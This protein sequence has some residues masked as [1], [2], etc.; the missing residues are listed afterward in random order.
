MFVA[1]RGTF[2]D[3]DLYV[4]LA[5]HGL[6]DNFFTLPFFDFIG[7]HVLGRD[8]NVRTCFPTKWIFIIISVFQYILVWVEIYGEGSIQY[9]IQSV[10]EYVDQMSVQFICRWDHWSVRSCLLLKNR[11]YTRNRNGMFSV[12]IKISAYKYVYW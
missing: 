10:V 12:V 6:R 8:W 11:F 1:L 2:S 4:C 5:L 7:R 3:T 9:I